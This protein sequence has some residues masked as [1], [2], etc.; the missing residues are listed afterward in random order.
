VKEYSTDKIRNVVLGGQRGCGKTTIAD[1]IAYSTGVNNRM[2]RVDDGTSLL[3]YQEDELAKKTTISSKLL[4]CEWKNT[5]INLL[6]G[7]GHSDF[8]GELIGSLK[9]ADSV[10]MV[11]NATAGVEVGTQIQWKYIEKLGIARFFFINKMEIENANWQASVDGIRDAFGT[12]AAAVHLP[13]GQAENFKGIVDLLRMKAYTFDDK[14]DPQESEIPA[15]MQ[16]LVDSE[17][18]KLIETAAE[19]DD[20]LLEKFF[21][22]GTLEKEDFIKGFSNGIIKGKVFP[23][24]CGAA[25]K[26]WGTKLMLD[27]IVDY[28]PS[29]DQMPPANV[30]K[31]G[32][33]EMTTL[34]ADPNGPVV[35]YVFKVHAEG[36]LGDMSFFKAMSGTVKPG[37]ELKNQ[38]TEVSERST[39]LYTFQGKNRIDATSVPAGDLGVFVK[40]KDTHIGNTLCSG[41]E[42]TVPA[43]EYPNPVM[44]VAIKPKSKG[45]E[46]KVANGLQKLREEDPTFKVISDPALKQMVLFAQGSTHIEVLCDKLKSRFHTE[47]D[48]ERP[49]IAYRETIRSKSETKY[50]HKK[51]SGG[52]GQ[53]GEVHIR[54]EPNE[55][56]AGFEFLDEIKGGVVPSKYIPAVEKGL[57]ESMQNGPLTGSPVVDVK[58]ALFYG[59][60]HEVDSSDMAFKIASSQAFKQGFMEAK[61]VLLEPI[62]NVEVIVPDDYTGDIMGDL[63]SRRAK[64]GGMEPEGRY[65]RIRAQVP[66]AEMYQ[67]SVDLRSMTSGQGFYS[68]DFS[69][70]EEVPHDQAQKVIDEAKAREEAEEA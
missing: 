20:A 45:D 69:H 44:D 65:Q 18:E 13:I 24:L 28:L 42:F 37:A 68:L 53:F 10:G 22:L 43:P 30:F 59:S 9:V 62:Y 61:P 35:A 36:H 12:Q 51:Q 64:I 54:L 39:Q 19:T 11:I 58:A 33:E 46:D 63:S 25:A 41:A 67:Y 26:N 1:A 8:L 52:R 6:D 21:D 3:D 50:R 34:P 5:K 56:G 4:A 31:T 14:G 47:V 23:I 60:Y 55:R 40:L 27:F 32:T 17:R 48:L 66:R 70:Y 38:N 49:R 29:P 57:V 16:D 7:P 15:D 2:G